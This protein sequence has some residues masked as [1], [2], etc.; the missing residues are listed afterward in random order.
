[1]KMNYEMSWITKMIIDD[2]KKNRNWF[3]CYDEEAEEM[4]PE[5]IPIVSTS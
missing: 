1:M 3:W 5:Q 2:E 4:A